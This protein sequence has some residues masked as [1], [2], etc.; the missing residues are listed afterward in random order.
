[1]LQKLGTRVGVALRRSASSS[2]RRRRVPWQSRRTYTHRMHSH[3]MSR[4]MFGHS[5]RVWNC[6]EQ[7]EGTV[8]V[9]IL[10][11][12]IKE[13]DAVKEYDLVYV[14]YNTYS[15]HSPLILSSPLIFSLCSAYK[16]VTSIISCRVFACASSL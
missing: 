13:G 12:F 1:M 9:D 11:W 10:E 8:E 15:S 16:C 7:G 2:A 14:A 6:P 3:H 5:V 4:R